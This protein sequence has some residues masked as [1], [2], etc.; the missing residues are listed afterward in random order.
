MI[1]STPQRHF[2]LLFFAFML[3]LC[4]SSTFV[5]TTANKAHASSPTYYV[6]AS[7]GNDNNDG[8]SPQSAWQS[9]SKVNATTFQPG[10]TILFKAG[11]I[12]SGQLHPLGSGSSQG[13]VI[14]IDEYGDSG[15]KPVVNGGGISPATVYLQDQAYWDINNLEITNTSSTPNYFS[16]VQVNN[17][18]DNTLDHIHISNLHV[19]NVSGYASAFYGDNAGISVQSFSN[20]T[21]TKWD[22]VLI[23]NNTIDN[24]DRIGIY[25]GINN[26][27]HSDTSTTVGKSTH[28]VIQNNTINNAGG[29]SILTETVDAPLIQYNV[30]SNGGTRTGGAGCQSTDYCNGASAGIWTCADHTTFQYNEVYNNTDANDGEAYDFDCGTTGDILQ[31]SYSHDN[32]LGFLVFYNGPSN[33]LV[34]YNISQNDQRGLFLRLG[35]VGDTQIYNNTLYVAPGLDTSVLT[36]GASSS[37]KLSNNIIYNQSTSD[38]IGDDGATWDHNLFFGNHPAHEPSDAHKITANPLFVAP[39]AGGNGLNAAS[40][41]RLQS[42]S[43]A[44]NA[45]LLVADN[46]KQDYFG[47][48]VSD[49]AAP[50]IGAYNGPGVD[51]NLAQGKPATSNSNLDDYGFSINNL[52]DDNTSSSYT[53]ASVG[54][55]DVSNNPIYVDVDLQSNQSISKVILWPRAGVHSVNDGS[56]DFPVAFTIQIAPN[57][58]TY[59]T[60]TTIAAQAD[61]KGTPQTYT[62]DAITA[63]H[64]RI[65]ATTL[66][67]PASDESS[68]YRLQFAELGVYA[69]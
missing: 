23:Q 14:T 31:Y 66:G 45:G 10:D 37:A 4:L 41:Y 3:S 34:R 1:R 35:S 46:G 40:A 32:P 6:D 52:T 64:V 33:N 11:Q 15:N 69:S 19:H 9:L 8:Q 54:S 39:G 57:G 65:V 24:V 62:F 47:N 22:D 49:T 21:N 36:D 50:N 12:W 60:V 2:F 17:T 63:Q 26:G 38:Y 20:T 7:N 58:G 61:P 68:N 27:H 16:G 56:A 43:P 18:T 29:D 48:P 44:I 67:S 5:F 13:G 30:A 42:G 59:Q 53:S 28:V 25:V 51:A 55:A